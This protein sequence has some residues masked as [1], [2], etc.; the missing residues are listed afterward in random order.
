MIGAVEITPTV[1][2]PTASEDHLWKGAIVSDTSREYVPNGEPPFNCSTGRT[3]MYLR[4]SSNGLV[5]GKALGNLTMPRICTISTRMEPNITQYPLRIDGTKD[6]QQFTLKFTSL[7]VGNGFSGE[8][9]GYVGLF[10]QVTCPAAIR[11]LTFPLSG[12]GSV[13]TT[14]NLHET[15]TGCG[16]STNDMMSSNNTIDMSDLNLNC[17]DVLDAPDKSPDL[18]ELCKS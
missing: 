6:S 12:P 15:M 4:V 10:K 18:S 5:R 13:K 7:Y 16:G 8:F 14:L 17:K 2:T 11:T 3:D 9:G 1:E